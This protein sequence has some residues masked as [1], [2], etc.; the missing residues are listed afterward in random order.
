MKAF[1]LP[2][3]FFN[4]EGKN[5][6]SAKL[7]NVPAFRREHQMPPE[8][9]VRAWMLVYYASFLAE[10]NFWNLLGKEVYD[11]HKSG[12]K[13]T[14]DVRKATNEAIGD[15]TTAE[16]K[17]ERIYDYCRTRIRNLEKDPAISEDELSR[18]K[19]NK[20]PSDTLKRGAGT[21]L[22]IDMLFAAM[23]NAAGFEA[24]VA[25]SADR[26]DVF[27]NRNFVSPYFLSTYH[28]AVNA[29]NKWLF[30]DP[31]GTYLPAGMLR[32]MLAL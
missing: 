24:R 7:T 18:M 27:F 11:S 6:R 10:Y 4:E 26:R 23:A 16:Q 17:L 1:N 32:L 5:V 29:N 8:N 13:V 12:M 14:D 25:K 21:P 3:V 22:D 2:G 15:A 30:F 19:E 9:E 31:A 20:N 28:I